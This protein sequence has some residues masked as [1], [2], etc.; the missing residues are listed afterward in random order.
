MRED[1]GLYEISL[2]S[3]SK[4]KS[5]ETFFWSTCVNSLLKMLN[6]VE[7]SIDENIVSRSR[8]PSTLLSYFQGQHS[9]VTVNEENYEKLLQA[10]KPLSLRFRFGEVSLFGVSPVII[11][12]ASELIT[13]GSAHEVSLI[14]KKNSQL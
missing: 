14:D 10:L 12:H 7:F 13:S 8:I 5:K 11:N 9:S 6:I 3:P 4:E 2:E 1:Q